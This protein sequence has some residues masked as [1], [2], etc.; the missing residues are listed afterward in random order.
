MAEQGDISSRFEVLNLFLRRE[1]P[2]FD[3][4]ISAPARAQLRPGAV[5]VLGLALVLGHFESDAAGFVKKLPAGF[6]FIDVL[7]PRA[8]PSAAGFFDVPGVDVDLD[9]RHF[10]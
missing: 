2:K 1:Q 9:I 4:V 5:L 3:K 7:A 10:R 8:A 6:D